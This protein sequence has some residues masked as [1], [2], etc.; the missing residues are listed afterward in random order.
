MAALALGGI[1]W[2]RDEA[3]TTSPAPI[4]H[5]IRIDNQIINPVTAE[6]V[7]SAI[8]R[9]EAAQ[10]QCLIIE[11]DTPGGLLESTRTIVK[12]M[13]SADVPIVVYVAP[14]GAR[15]GS[16]GVFLTLAAHVAAMAP[17]T[18][19]GAA[20]PVTAEG[21]GPVK[22]LIRRFKEETEPSAKK[23]RT[24]TETEEVTEVDPMSEKMLHDTVAWVS[25]IATARGRNVAWAR[26]SVEESISVT[27]AEALEQHVI[28]LVAKNMPELLERLEGRV[29][30]LLDGPVTLR[31]K[32]AVVQRVELG[33]RQRILLVLTN[34]TVAYLLMMLGFWGLVTEITHPGLA[35]PGIAGAICLVLALFAFQTLPVNY[36][37]VALIAIGL[38]L[39][40]AEIKII[41]YGLL[42]LGGLTCLTLGSLMLID[43]PYAFMR[44]SLAV[45]LPVVIGT[46][47]IALVLVGAVIRTHARSVTTGAQGLIGEVGVADT[48][49]RPDGQVFVHGEVWNATAT[50]PAA[51][52]QKVRVVK[53]DHLSLT[54]EPL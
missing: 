19:I 48:D 3:P 40:I 26:R 8:D 49:L 39:L 24:P 42:T 31:T 25:A 17:T 45:I 11:L 7:S 22:K 43:S 2:A 35:F 1:V 14:S 20:H 6:Y 13:M 27:E 28:D 44:V 41:S 16:A 33:Q 36:A 5:L 15:A 37:G 18:N 4:V 51:R 46:A 34:P 32:D 38:A 47:L 53:L 52:G 50:R 21:G 10:A 23:K 54:V 12:R 9:A 30:P 29:V